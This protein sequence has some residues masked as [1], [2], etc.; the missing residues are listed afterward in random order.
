[1]SKLV[2]LYDSA[3]P[4]ESV[5]VQYWAPAGVVE[6]GA[7]GAV[8]ISGSYRSSNGY[9]SSEN[10]NA[11]RSGNIYTSSAGFISTVETSS[12]S[13]KYSHHFIGSA[14]NSN[15]NNGVLTGSSLIGA[16]VYN[17]AQACWTKKV[18][19]FVCEVSNDPHPADGS[20]K[21]DQCGAVESFRISGVFADNNGKIQIYDMTA[22]GTKIFGHTWNTR[23]SGGWTKM[24]YYCNSNEMLD[25]YHL[26]WVVAFTHHKV[27]GGGT[28]NKYCTG[29]VRYL[30]PLVSS[31]GGLY[32]DNENKHQ[33][34]AKQR[35]WDEKNTY[36]FFT[37]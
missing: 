23:P 37:K 16:G 17:N 11:Q 24:C 18:K 8:H 14:S 32:F 29:K 9:N 3:K 33:I 1:M 27:C 10:I 2:T 35:R 13:L 36:P 15:L 6:Y 31:G 25:M 34:I 30:Q 4:R 21:A 12:T 28:K 22:G 5:N 7:T 19:G 20:D 26:G